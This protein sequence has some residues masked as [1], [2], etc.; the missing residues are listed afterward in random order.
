MSQGIRYKF[1]S[2]A[3]QASVKKHI[4]KHTACVYIEKTSSQFTFN[5][6]ADNKENEKNCKQTA[7]CIGFI[8][9]LICKKALSIQFINLS[10]FF[11]IKMHL[12][13]YKFDFYQYYQD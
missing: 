11:V 6:A 10:I 1:L 13:K 8:L 7:L 3:L 2:L 12:L 5:F 9:K 4:F